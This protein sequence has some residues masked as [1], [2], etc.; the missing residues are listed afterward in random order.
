MYTHREPT[1]VMTQQDESTFMSQKESTT[2]Y[3]SFNRLSDK[4]E[5]ILKSSVKK[6][7]EPIKNFFIVMPQNYLTDYKVNLLISNNII[8]T[9]SYFSRIEPGKALL[10]TSLNTYNRDFEGADSLYRVDFFKNNVLIRADKLEFDE[11]KLTG[12]YTGSDGSI[13]S[14]IHDIN[15]YYEPEPQ[16]YFDKIEYM[17]NDN[18]TN[19]IISDTLLPDCD[20]V[21]LYGYGMAIL[22]HLK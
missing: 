10:N 20:N 18:N 14:D 11:I 5:I 17:D 13:S 16:I 4:D 21:I 1:L 6:I 19:R 7:T 8:A 9:T 12:V 22:R 3:V 15:F 2:K